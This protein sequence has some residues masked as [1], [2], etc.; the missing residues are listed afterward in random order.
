MSAVDHESEGRST[1]GWSRARAIG[2]RLCRSGGYRDD[3]REGARIFT[4]EKTTYGITVKARR[5][6]RKGQS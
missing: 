4:F 5:N 2:L 1:Y 6:V 3:V